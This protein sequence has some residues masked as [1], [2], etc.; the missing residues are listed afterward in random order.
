MLPASHACYTSPLLLVACSRLS[1]LFLVAVGLRRTCDVRGYSGDALSVCSPGGSVRTDT[2]MSSAFFPS[3]PMRAERRPLPTP[4]RNGQP[5]SSNRKP[6][7][8]QRLTALP[9]SMSTA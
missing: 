9:V 3:W 1:L 8:N 4:L 2:L 7:R 6:T 5:A